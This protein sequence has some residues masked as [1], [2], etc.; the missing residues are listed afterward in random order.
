MCGGV[1]AYERGDL[2]HLLDVAEEK[3]IL[4]APEIAAILDERE[5]PVEYET[6]PSVGRG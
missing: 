2:Q 6:R 4:T 3:G 1:A 5:L